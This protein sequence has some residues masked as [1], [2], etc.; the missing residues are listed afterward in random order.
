MMNR[1]PGGLLAA[2]FA[3]PSKFFSKRI[4]IVIAQRVDE[5]EFAF[6]FFDYEV[7]A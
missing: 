6:F 1:R 3:F 5:F 4:V 2:G 7:A